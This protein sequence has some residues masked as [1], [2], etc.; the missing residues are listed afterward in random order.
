MTIMICYILFDI[1][2]Q[3]HIYAGVQENIT[4][5]GNMESIT[6]LSENVI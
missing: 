3:K 6:S 4:I 2:R 1:M 5:N